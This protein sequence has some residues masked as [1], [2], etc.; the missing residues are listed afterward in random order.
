MGCVEMGSNMSK[1]KK[2]GRWK[3]GCG[4]DMG[5]HERKCGCGVRSPHLYRLPR[6]ETGWLSISGVIRNRFMG[7]PMVSVHEN[8]PCR[9]SNGS[10][11][12]DE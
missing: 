1:P 12:S 11:L 2:V 3:L 8:N 10:V 5:F 7:I 4:A 6:R 9:L